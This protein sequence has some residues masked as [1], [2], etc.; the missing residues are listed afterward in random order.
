MFLNCVPRFVRTSKAAGCL[1]FAAAMSFLTSV[2]AQIPTIVAV[3]PAN[4]ATDVSPTAVV[5]TF[6]E[7]MD[8]NATM[9]T[10]QEVSNA[11]PAT[12]PTSA[13]WSADAKTLTCTPISPFP[14]P[15]EIFWYAK[16]K[17]T[18]GKKLQGQIE[19]VF[20]TGSG[21]GADSN[22]QA[23]TEFNIE[24]QRSYQQE[25]VGLPMPAEGVAR[26]SVFLAPD[27]TASAVSLAQPTGVVTNLFSNLAV[28]P[29]F[30]V[31]DS[32]TN[33]AALEAAWPDGPYLFDVQG[34]AFGTVT[35]ELDL[36]K[37]SPP[38]VANFA[39]AQGVDPAQAFTL[40]WD[41]FTNAARTGGITVYVA[42]S[43]N[44]SEG[45]FSTNLP[46]TVQSV[47][48]PPNTLQAGANYNGILIFNNSSGTNEGVY[49]ALASQSAVTY[50]P[51]S[52][53]L[54]LS[55]AAWSDGTFSFDVTSAPGQT[56][57]IEYSATLQAGSWITLVT[58]NSVSGRV[59]IPDTP[60]NTSP[61]RFYRARPGS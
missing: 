42:N 5:F 45:V 7:T 22:R 8:T 28:P 30:W 61:Y 10:F 26:A 1:A 19:G 49:A 2:K 15:D 13:V 11:P 53:V 16:G 47:T 55:N 21:S 17:D 34:A 37:P 41:T 20:Y 44:S 3:V 59:T 29:V 14:S 32:G 36:S 23:Y 27:L 25:D 52:T 24:I 46:S 51:L 31:E 56:V 58:T 18:L 48:I 60:P 38:H 43:G 54:G 40:R 39:A 9:A 12:L 6:S 35:V 57:I 33:L 50:F 4:E